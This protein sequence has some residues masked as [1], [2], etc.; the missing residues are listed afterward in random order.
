MIM[1]AVR[2]ACSTRLASVTDDTQRTH[3]TRARRL[4]P[5]ITYEEGALNGLLT[6]AE[7]GMPDIARWMS[8]RISAALW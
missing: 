1:R 3:R 7:T 8:A 4:F 5:E 2:A 6:G